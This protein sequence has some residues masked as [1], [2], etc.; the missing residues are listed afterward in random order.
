MLFRNHYPDA[1]NTAKSNA[2]LNVR[3]VVLLT[4]DYVLCSSHKFEIIKKIG[5]DMI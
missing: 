2:Y 3:L 4:I 1:F 5:V